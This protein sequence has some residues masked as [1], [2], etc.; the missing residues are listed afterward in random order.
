MIESNNSNFGQDP[1]RLDK[2]KTGSQEQMVPDPVHD[3]TISRASPAL[4]DITRQ[5]SRIWQQLL[6]IESVGL[7]QNYFD[8]GGDSILAVQ[9]FAQIEQIFKVKL[10]VATLFDAPTIEELARVLRREDP[11]F[12]W[13]HWW[14]FSRPVH[15]RPSFAYMEPAEMF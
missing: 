9:L 3:S 6:G 4:D 15:D 12:G 2:M 8:L 13:L 7:E 10:P 14:P 11:A 5:L 1:Q